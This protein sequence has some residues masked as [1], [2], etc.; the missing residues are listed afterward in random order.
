M[1]RMRMPQTPSCTFRKLRFD[2]FLIGC[3]VMYLF[4]ESF[5]FGTPPPPQQQSLNCIVSEDA[6]GLVEDLVDSASSK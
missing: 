1:Q 2:D 4:R 3:Y 5:F 6:N